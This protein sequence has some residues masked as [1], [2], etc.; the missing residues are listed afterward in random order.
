MA[1]ITLNNRATNRSDTASA[2]QVFTATSATAA[3]F[4]D[5]SGG[6]LLQVVSGTLTSAFTTSSTSFVATGL[7]VDI[8]PSATSS[9]VF[10]IATCYLDDNTD[11]QQIWS[12]IYRDSTNLGH[13]SYGMMASYASGARLRSN[14]SMSFL[15]SPSST[16]AL[17]Y[18]VYIKTSGNTTSFNSEGAI[19]SITAMEIGV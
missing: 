14:H 18:E 15:D 8:T 16:S 4:Q 5:A 19:V 1:I 6:K 13:A 17:T 9:K 7:N 3:D 11:T 12:T 10:V 2:G